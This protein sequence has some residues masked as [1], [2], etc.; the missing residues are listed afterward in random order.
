MSDEKEPVSA[1]ASGDR[2]LLVAL[3]VCCAGPMVVIIVLVSVLGVAVGPALAISLGLVAAGLCVALMA[4][5]H[6]RLHN[7]EPDRG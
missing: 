3:A 2:P 6:H 5:R 7:E 4:G 1:K